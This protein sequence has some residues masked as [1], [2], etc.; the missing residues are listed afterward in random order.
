MSNAPGQKSPPRPA[1]Y[2]RQP[3]RQ[4]PP[5]DAALQQRARAGVALAVISMIGMIGAFT[6]VMG[7]NAQRSSDVDGVA[8]VI[9]AIG[10]WLTATAMSRARRAG[11]ARPRAA[12]LAMVLG[13][14]GLVISALLL[15][16][17]ASDA[18][19]LS[20]F[21]H[22]VRSATTSSAIRACQLQLEN[23]TSGLSNG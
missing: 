11:S 3:P 9:A 2:Q 22:C 12:V 17:F 15:P 20:Q 23:S 14:A 18:P 4:P 5:A 1:G 8:L 13:I 10:V 6:V 16:T 21:M 19:Q 7:S